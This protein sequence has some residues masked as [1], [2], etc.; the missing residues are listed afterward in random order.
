MIISGLQKLTLLDY[1]NK[2]ACIIFTGGCN[3]KCSYCQ[4]SD[5]IGKNPIIINEEEVFEYL[6]KRKKVLDGVVVTGGEPTIHKDL[7]AFIKKIK[8]LKL[9]VK[10]DTNGSNPMMLEELINNHLIDYIAMDIKNTFD[11]YKDVIKI[12]TNLDNIKKSIE[13]IKNSNIDHEFRTTIIKNFHTLDKIQTICAYL[14][15]EEKYYLQNFEASE[16]VLD[17]SLISF[18]KEE[19]INMQKIINEK[20]PNVKVRG[21]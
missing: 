20:Y 3:F 4:N 6:K 10:L 1:P 16:R 21:L 17:K 13:L 15:K 9:L 19:L 12:N 8:D 5:L 18:T 7:P 2:T 11:D 14:G